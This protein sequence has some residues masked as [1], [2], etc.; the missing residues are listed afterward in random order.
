MKYLELCSKISV[1]R[2]FHFSSRVSNERIFLYPALQFTHSFGKLTCLDEK[3][4]TGNATKTLPTAGYSSPAL[5][6]LFHPL[7]EPKGKKVRP[8]VIAGAIVGAVVLI[9]IIVAAIYFERQHIRKFLNGEPDAAAEIGESREVKEIMD[10]EVL[11]E[12]DGQDKRSVHGGFLT[13]WR[14]SRRGNH[15]KIAELD[16]NKNGRIGDERDNVAELDTERGERR[17]TGPLAELDAERDSQFAVELD[18]KRKSLADINEVEVS[19]PP[20]VALK[21][22]K[23]PLEDGMFF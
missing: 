12:L 20:L 13:G 5:A 23:K 18:A 16:V 3:R 22:V 15:G 19:P 11:G 6:A 9:G 7:P 21:D 2:K 14:E 10:R 17:S 8:G 1:A 4:G